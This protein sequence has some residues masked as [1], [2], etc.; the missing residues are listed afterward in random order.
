MLVQVQWI[1]RT[2]CQN[3]LGLNFP[4][5]LRHISTQSILLDCDSVVR[6]TDQHKHTA[7]RSESIVPTRCIDLDQ[8]YQDSYDSLQSSMSHTY[9]SCL[10]VAIY[11]DWCYRSISYL[12]R[13]G[14]HSRVAYKVAR[15]L[16]F[17]R[18]TVL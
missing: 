3:S 6:C 12:S 15:G 17:A 10:R 13:C 18:L 8:G 16:M 7:S 1:L 5:W 14:D 2:A 9:I 4:V 11:T